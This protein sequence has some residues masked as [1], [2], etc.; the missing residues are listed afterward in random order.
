MNWNGIGGFGE[1]Q[2]IGDLQLKWVALLAIA[3]C[4]TVCSILPEGQIDSAFKVHFR[5]R[6]RFKN[7]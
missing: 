5:W 7:S 1:R 4:S 3:N 2:I 6:G